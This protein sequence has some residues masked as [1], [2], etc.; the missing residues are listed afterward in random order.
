MRALYALLVLMLSSC[1]AVDRGEAAARRPNVVMIISDDQSWTDF[2]FMG[3]EEIRIPHLDALAARSLVYERGYVPSSL[4][5]PSLASMITGLYPHEHGITGNDPPRGQQRDRMLRHIEAAVTLPK[6]LAK[7]GYRSL[8]TGKWWEGNCRCGGFSDGMTHGERARGGRHGDEGLKIGRRTMQPIYDFIADCGDHP[9]F[10]WYAPLLPHNPHNPPERL[11]EKYRREGESEYVAKYHAMCEWFD[12]T[13]G[14]LLAHLREQGLEEDTLVVFVTD[15]GWIQRDDAKGYAARSKRSPYEGGVRTPIMFSWPGHVTPQRRDAYASSVDLAPTILR[16]C[17][18]A[19]PA[20][21]SGVD[22]LASDVRR[23]AVFGALFSHDV[24]DL[25]QPTKGLQAR[26]VVRDGWK[27]I[28]PQAEGRPAELFDL[29]AD[30]HER[31]DL[32]S[33]QPQRAAAL[34]QVLDGWWRLEE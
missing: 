8:Q 27:L 28:A 17:G 10:L 18:A 15:N 14:Q 12:E 16:A 4:C 1:A 19:V 5:R 23:D 31:A 25:D 21:M 34:Q 9:F 3:H 32:A 7:L 33:T 29:G 6:L 20:A 22:L 13:C 30:P 24:A 11:L 2:G 26:Y